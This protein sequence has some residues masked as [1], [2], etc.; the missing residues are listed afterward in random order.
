MSKPPEERISD[1]SSIQIW[2]SKYFR[3]NKYN[4]TLI[5]EWVGW[6]ITVEGRV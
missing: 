3:I 1:R 2:M 4:F 6:F 5:E